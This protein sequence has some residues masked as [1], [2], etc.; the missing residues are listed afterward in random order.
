MRPLP[1]TGLRATADHPLLSTLLAPLLQ[2][3]ASLGD[4]TPPTAV[5]D[6][7]AAAADHTAAAEA[8]GRAGS[9]LLESTGTAP[10]AVPVAARTGTEVSELAGHHTALAALVTDAYATRATVAGRLDT[11][12]DNFKATAGP[13]LDKA[14]SQSDLDPVI[15]LASQ[16]IREGVNEV[17][18]AQDEM[19]GHTR[20][21]RELD[22]GP[23]APGVTVPPGFAAAPGVPAAGPGAT[24][25]GPG[26]P[27]VLDPQQA[28]QLAMQQAAL[29][30]GVQLG[31]VALDAGVEIGS[32][33]IDGVV[34]VA[35][36]GIDTGA[37]LAEQGISTMAAGATGTEGGT[38]P[39]LNPPAPPGPAAPGDKP[40]LFG[41]L[42]GAPTAPAPGPAP[43]ND[44][45]D[46]GAEGSGP[47][48]FPEQQPAPA[49]PP[50]APVAPGSDQPGT[51][52]AV[53]PPAGRTGPGAGADQEQQRP[54]RPGQAGVT[55]E[56][57]S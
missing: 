38:A 43:K 4:G 45:S 20:R 55:S 42:G 11:I 50:P 23:G 40:V 18:Y 22:R 53:V 34:Q 28:A 29:A 24:T 39:G 47:V 33:L 7:L 19:D 14:R 46:S 57:Q 31:T 41:G 36:H 56:D 51:T 15:G 8:P 48:F 2:L 37:Q 21:A 1:T 25:T 12:I 16:A 26:A 49:P 27:A 35:T 54:R 5:L 6:A 13:M 52:G 10:A 9:Y 44:D 30:A 17:S 32:K 3:R